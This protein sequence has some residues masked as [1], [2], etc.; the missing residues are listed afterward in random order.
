MNITADDPIWTQDIEVLPMIQAFPALDTLEEFNEKNVVLTKDHKRLFSV[1]SQKAKILHHVEAV[2]MIDNAIQVAYGE[3]P[4]IELASYKQGAQI[5]A[6]FK[7]P[8]EPLIDLGSGDINT[9]HV[10]LYNS[11]DRSMPFK[12]RVGAYR[13]ICDNGMVLGNDIASITGKDLLDSWSPEGVAT[14]VSKMMEKSI[15]VF[16]TWKKWQ[17]IELAYLDALEAI[18]NKL[19]K[20][21][22]GAIEEREMEFPMSIWDYYNVLTAFST[23]ESK[24][25]R[26]KT[27]FDGTISNIFYSRKNPLYK[28][29]SE[30]GIEDVPEPEAA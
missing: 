11:Y 22:V 10:L 26:A 12:L 6:R 7:L 8:E 1:V 16:D 30:V 24:T 15:T 28:L 5:A 9:F 18:G 29:Y 19:P 3:P 17:Q 2:E 27:S 20:K 14:K 21:M 25:H 23:H 13:A 4:R